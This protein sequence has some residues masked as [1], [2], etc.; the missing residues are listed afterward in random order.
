MVKKK[1]SFFKVI[2]PYLYLIPCLLIFIIFVYFPFVKTIYLSLFN[3][4]PKGKAVL[5]TGFGNYISLFESPVFIKSLAV[6]FK[7]VILVVIPS[8]IIGLCTALL[9]N[10]K[11]KASGIFKVM[12]AI[13][14]AVSS[15][16]AAIIWMMLFHPSIGF[17]NYALKTNIG[18]LTDEKWAIAAV[19][20]VTVWM[21][22]GMNFIF[23]LSGLQTISKEL[24][25][26]AS[27]DGANYFH[28]LASITLPGLSPTLFFLMVV[29]IINAF[30]AFGQVNIMT[31]GGPGESTNVLVFSIYRDAF[32][33]NR[34][35]MASAES[36][37]LFVIMLVVTLVQFKY[38]ERSVF[39]K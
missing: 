4:N 19:S 10:V 2:E 15:A 38:E 12:Y 36:V 29:D 22:I 35:G 28:K 13:P 24:Y 1:R 27:I 26:S 5:F 3:T 8:I 21:N 18:W 20:M 33:N 34:F 39:Y 16:C 25:E 6:T 9:A 11:L 32:F 23:L 30:Q 17:L 31:N 7:F 37:I 14:M